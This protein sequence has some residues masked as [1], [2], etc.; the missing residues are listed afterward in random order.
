MIDEVYSELPEIDK[1]FSIISQIRKWNFTITEFKKTYNLYLSNGTIKESNI[2]FV[3][4]TLF[5]FSIIG[6]RPKNRSISFF[7]YKNKEARFNFNENIVVHRG[8]LKALQ[9]L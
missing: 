4:Q 3:L 6:N 5:N 9:I 2:D 1:I 8:L 7:R